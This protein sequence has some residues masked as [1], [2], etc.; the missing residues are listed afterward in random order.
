MV[1]G[2]AEL[3]VFSFSISFH[4]FLKLVE[5]DDCLLKV[6]SDFKSLINSLYRKLFK[7][8][9]MI[10]ITIVV[11]VV[12]MDELEEIRKRRIE[13]MKKRIEND[14]IEI[15]IEVNDGNFEEKVI[16]QSGTVLVVVDFWAEWCMPC[17]MIGP[18]LEKIAEEYRGKL[19]L[20]KIEVDKSPKISQ[21][22]GISSIPAVKIFRDGKVVD[23]FVGA[24]PESQVR[25]YFDKCVG[26]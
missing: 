19:V 25:E 9:V 26:D 23:E 12:N 2:V 5:V 1:V 8:V 6:V 11:L 16:K 14:R 15:K 3:F 24:L 22:Y 20:A 4:L 10:L 7:R 17:Q 18:V 21:M 13:R